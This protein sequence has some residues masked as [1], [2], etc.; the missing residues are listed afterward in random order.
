MAVGWCLVL[1]FFF[2]SFGE[3]KAP[4]ESGKDFLKK[5][6]LFLVKKYYMFTV[7]NFGSIGKGSLKNNYP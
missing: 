5:I 6:T 4:N 2:F 1:S 7:D 3:E